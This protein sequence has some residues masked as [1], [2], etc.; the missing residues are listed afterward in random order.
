MC[1]V[2]GAFCEQMK[3]DDGRMD[4][5]IIAGTKEAGQFLKQLKQQGVMGH[6]HVE[7]KHQTLSSES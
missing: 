1:W 5:K 6:H 2:L 4:E 3:T 7:M